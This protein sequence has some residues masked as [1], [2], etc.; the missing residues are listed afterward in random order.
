MTNAIGQLESTIRFFK[1]YGI[2]MDIQTEVI[3]V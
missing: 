2:R 3:I 1:K